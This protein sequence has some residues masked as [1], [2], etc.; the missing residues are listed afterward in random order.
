MDSDM[1]F[2]KKMI[3]MSEVEGFLGEEFKRAGY[4]HSTIRRTPMGMRILVFASK[5]GL[6]IGRGGS[7]IKE[8]TT[9]LEKQFGFENPQLDVQ[10][11]ESPD[12]DANIVAGEIAR[13]LEMNISHKR[14]GNVMVKRIME[15]GAV[16]VEILMSG[17]MGSAKARRDRFTEG[18]LKHCGDIAQEMVDSAQATANMKAGTIGIK[19][20]IMKMR[21]QLRLEA[22]QNINLEK[23]EEKKE[24]A[25]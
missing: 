12:L 15:S 21:S 11:V 17:K 22:M 14:I 2:L 24:E 4:S 8:M 25:K 9:K 5:P 18:Y 13:A 19:V 10:Q 23:P 1:K 3:R 6:I 20:K 7:K 16:G